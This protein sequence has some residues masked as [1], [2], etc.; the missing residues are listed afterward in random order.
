MRNNR[1]G[2]HQTGHT[3]PVLAILHSRPA[4]NDLFDRFY[5]EL[6]WLSLAAH[7]HLSLS[8]FV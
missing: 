8:H 2:E 6:I 4:I 7:N 3:A 5:L 1:W